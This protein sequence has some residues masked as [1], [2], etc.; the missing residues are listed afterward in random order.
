MAYCPICG[1][2]H[3]PETL[4]VNKASDVLRHAGIPQRSKLSA[5]EINKLSRKAS[6]SF[7]IFLLRFA[8][9]IC[10]VIL[11]LVMLRWLISQ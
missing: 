2:D 8:G 5:P 11:F 3:D 10:L 4:C 6:R 9:A 7:L 1:T